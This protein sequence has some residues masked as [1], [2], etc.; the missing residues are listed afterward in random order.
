MAFTTTIQT[1][2]VIWVQRQNYGLTIPVY[3]RIQRDIKSSVI[4]SLKSSKGETHKNSVLFSK[5]EIH[6]LA[7]YIKNIGK[8]TNYTLFFTEF[9][10]SF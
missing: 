8:D 1:A 9:D 4:C 2:D 6:S 3:I 10:F 5:N 7:F